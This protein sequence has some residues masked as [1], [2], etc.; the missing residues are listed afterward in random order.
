MSISTET[1]QL[2]KG[3]EDAQVQINNL[4]QQVHKLRE[5]AVYKDQKVRLALKGAS[6]ELM[7]YKAALED[8]G[9]QLQAAQSRVAEMEKNAPK[10]KKKCRRTS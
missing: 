2:K 9:K 1:K 6:A 10:S 4:S 5:D 3:L 7:Q 8:V